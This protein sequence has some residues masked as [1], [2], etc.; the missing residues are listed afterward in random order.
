MLLKKVGEGEQ[1]RFV[2][3]R[4][5]MEWANVAGGLSAYEF[6]HNLLVGNGYEEVTLCLRSLPF[7]IAFCSRVAFKVPS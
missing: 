2:V 6:G 5:R 7:M 1:L 4:N 3:C